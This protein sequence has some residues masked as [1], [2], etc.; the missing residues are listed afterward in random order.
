MGLFFDT[1]KEYTESFRK[2]FTYNPFKNGYILW[3]VLWGLPVPVVAT[4]VK[5][6]VKNMPSM[7][8][9]LP[10]TFTGLLETI[11]NYGIALADDPLLWATH[12]LTPL[13]MGV[14]FGA[15]GT[16]N[17]EKSER[18]KS[19]IKELRLENQENIRINKE[20]L[21]SRQELDN[22]MNSIPLGIIAI[23]AEYNIGREY[24]K[25]TE[26]IFETQNIKD[27][28][29][30][31]LL[32]PKT[33]RE[34][35]VD[36]EEYIEILFSNTRSS[37]E[38]LA[39]ANPV[40]NFEY[41]TYTRLGETKTKY[42]HITFHPH[43]INNIVERVIVIVGDETRSEEL[44]RQV[45][46]D[47]LE[48][49]R[50]IDLIY[51][52]IHNDPDLIA[53]F[54]TESI[55]NLEIIENTLRSF[56]NPQDNLEAVNSIFRLVHQIKGSSRSYN[57]ISLSLRAHKFEDQLAPLRT[58]NHDISK[59]QQVHLL[60]GLSNIR[61]ELERI[62]AI[63]R[64][65]NPQKDFLSQFIF[66]SNLNQEEWGKIHNAIVEL[67][68]IG[69]Q[70]KH[71]GTAFENSLFQP[72]DMMDKTLDPIL[73]TLS[74]SVHNT[75]KQLG[76]EIYPLKIQIKSKDIPVEVLQELPNLLTPLL[77]N[78]V[79][80]GIESA[81]RRLSIGKDA[82]GL[83]KL[84]MDDRNGAFMIEIRDNGRGID[85]G[86]IKQVAVA[87]GVAKPERMNKMKRSEIMQFIFAPGFSTL[88]KTSEISGRG[89]GLD[90]IKV[91]V[92]TL[93]GRI[94]VASKPNRGTIFRLYFPREEVTQNQGEE[95]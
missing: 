43:R 45:E 20:L 65:L 72:K 41:V 38:M 24:S 67:V 68:K 17:K 56:R 26:I 6:A 29:F 30:L 21:R 15:M 82:R 69:D 22:I 73:K 91:R 87:Q 57:F 89:V 13:I 58:S 7:I 50:D 54:I 94:K 74:K 60:V 92:N 14:V 3:G 44:A 28:Y 76:K 27:R 33:K 12:F 66:Q 52:I 59:E 85:I 1:I 51:Q 8:G 81:S 80:H 11:K 55:K 88:S 86:K 40:K 25:Y 93:N 19:Q 83:I 46:K 2:A 42:L 49:A 5:M 31:D 4:I 75:A 78:A 18:I 34:A 36:L 77:M 32:Y 79:E 9:D 37:P 10:F 39:Q 71:I 23:D 35:R 64:K 90:I 62:N 70:I 61:V 84:T 63:H 95:N 47:R 16:I 48:H 53:G